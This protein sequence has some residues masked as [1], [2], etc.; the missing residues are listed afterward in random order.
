MFTF[1]WAPKNTVQA[2]LPIWPDFAQERSFA[3]TNARKMLKKLFFIY[4][5]GV[6]SSLMKISLMDNIQQIADVVQLA[7]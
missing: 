1:A 6:D 5:C 4:I 2:A 3:K 7:L